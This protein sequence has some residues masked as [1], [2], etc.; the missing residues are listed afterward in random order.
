[1]AALLHVGLQRARGVRGL[2]IVGTSS[3]LEREVRAQLVI[4]DRLVRDALEADVEAPPRIDRE[5]HAHRLRV[6]VERGPGVEVRDHTRGR[7]AV[8]VE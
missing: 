4:A 3:L 6:A 7:I 8:L 1:V 2:D 5:R